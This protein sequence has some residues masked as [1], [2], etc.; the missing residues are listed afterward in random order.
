[1]MFRHDATLQFFSNTPEPVGIELSPDVPHD[2]AKTGRVSDVF[3]IV[4]Q[5]D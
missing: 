4:S 5:S 1:M 2:P 3:L